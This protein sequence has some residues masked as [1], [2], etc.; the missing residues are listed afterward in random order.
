MDRPDTFKWSLNH[1]DKFSVSSMYQAFLD[2]NVVPNNS[3]LW[4]IKVPL[5]IR[6]FLWLLYKEAILTKDNLVKRNWH[7]NMLCYFCNNLEIIQH[8]FFNCALAKFLSR[9]IQMTFGLSAPQNI[10]H[11]HGEWSQNM[12]NTNKGLLFVGLSSM[13]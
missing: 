2:T 3:H 11:V 13:F 1:N 4:K 9:V 12:N 5:K 10:K 8:L 7:G 6:V